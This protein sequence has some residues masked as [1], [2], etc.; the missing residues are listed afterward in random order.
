MKKLTQLVKD[1]P[2]LTTLIVLVILYVIYYFFLRTPSTSTSTGSGLRTMC[3]GGV[4][5]YPVVTDNIMYK[6]GGVSP[7]AGGHGAVIGGGLSVPFVGSASNTNC[8]SL[9]QQINSAWRNVVSSYNL[10]M[11]DKTCKR[12]IVGLIS[13]IQL[14]NGNQLNMA[15]NVN[16]SASCRNNI[17]SYQNDV[18]NWL[19]LKKQ[20]NSIGCAVIEKEKTFYQ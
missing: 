4:I 7:G 5:G 14:T 13:P 18:N 15:V 2:Y 12:K 10:I 20:Y 1:H 8:A 6:A 17:A 9:Q 11:N 3:G 19:S 16:A